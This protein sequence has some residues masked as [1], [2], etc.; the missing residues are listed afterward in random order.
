LLLYC[1]S[2]STII[3]GPFNILMEPKERAIAALKQVAQSAGHRDHAGKIVF[4][5][6]TGSDMITSPTHNAVVSKQFGAHEG[7][8]MISET[9]RYLAGKEE[10]L[11]YRNNATAGILPSNNSDD[12][13]QST[14]ENHGIATPPTSASEGFSSQSTNQDGSMCQLSQLSQLAAAQQPLASGT[15]RPKLAISPTAGQKRT[16]DGQI[17]LARSS[18]PSARSHSRNVSAVSNISNS[19]NRIGEVRNVKHNL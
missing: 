15:T 2:I 14:S 9:D 13:S 16:A 17:K 1:R 5:A 6:T 18:P 12:N 4:N 10:G 11:G 8:H 3:Q 19:S 7:P